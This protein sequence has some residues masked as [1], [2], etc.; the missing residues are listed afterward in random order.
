MN[1]YGRMVLDD[2]SRLGLYEIGSKVWYK[3][4]YID[5]DGTLKHR[6][7]AGEV[8]ARGLENCDWWNDY[9][10]YF[11]DGS[12]GWEMNDGNSVVHGVKPHILKTFR[13][14]TG[15]FAFAPK[16]DVERIEEDM[17]TIND[18]KEASTKLKDMV[19]EFKKNYEGNSNG[20]RFKEGDLVVVV[21]KLG[22][23]V[24]CVVSCRARDYDG[25]RYNSYIVFLPNDFRGEELSSLP[26]DVLCK[27]STYKFGRGTFIYTNESGL[28]GLY[29]VR[30][31]K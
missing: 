11:S 1:W 14:W 26:E 3:V 19:D 29:P 15:T 2:L 17:V 21:H 24:G 31:D 6:A 16:E 8:V 20:S 7:Y 12:V 18:I 9:L 22:D 4:P 27:F 30:G 28:R 10:L 5:L 23:V 25:D 13:G